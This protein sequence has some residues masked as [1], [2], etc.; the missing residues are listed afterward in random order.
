M[1]SAFQIFIVRTEKKLS[2]GVVFNNWY[3][4]NIENLN[5]WP[6]ATLF[7]FRINPIDQTKPGFEP[8]HE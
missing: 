7:S 4:E 3:I 6:L 1:G 5:G 2:V 8:I